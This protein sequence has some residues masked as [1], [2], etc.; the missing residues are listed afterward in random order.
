MSLRTLV[1]IDNL[2]DTIDNGVRSMGRRIAENSLR[3]NLSRGDFVDPI[4][5]RLVQQWLDREEAKRNVEAANTPDGL[6]RRNTE[7]TERAASAAERS[8]RSAM[9]AI[10]ISIVALAVAAWP[11]MQ[12]FW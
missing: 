1:D 5:Q 10:G 11:Y 4:E 2:A 12:K 3:Q 6:A 8:A 7:A 9:I